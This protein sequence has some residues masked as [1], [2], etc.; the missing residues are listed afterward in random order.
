MPHCARGV[1]TANG[2][3]NHITKI[4]RKKDK[5]HLSAAKNIFKKFL[6]KNQKI[7]DIG[8]K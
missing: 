2:I 4:N 7:L 6:E 5:Q 1:L 8:N 3:A